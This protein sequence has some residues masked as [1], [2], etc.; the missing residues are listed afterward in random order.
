M[1]LAKE[2]NQHIDLLFGEGVAE[3]WHAFA[4][5]FD[6]MGH[7]PWFEPLAYIDEGRS[8]ACAA[9]GFAVAMRAAGGREKLLAAGCIGLLSRHGGGRAS[10]SGHKE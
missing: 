3:G 6:L 7:L 9:G 1:P 5:F 8:F 10:W 2:L 4:A